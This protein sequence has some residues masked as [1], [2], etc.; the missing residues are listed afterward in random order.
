MGQ[1]RYH[2]YLSEIRSKKASEAV[3]IPIG[4]GPLFGYNVIFYDGTTLLISADDTKNFRHNLTNERNVLVNPKSACITPDGILT[5]ES[6][7]LEVPLSLGKFTGVKEVALIATHL[8]S[9]Q[10]GGTITSYRVY[11]NPDQQ[12]AWGMAFL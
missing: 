12:D 7:E 8:F 11:V 1:I 3:A 4:I 10:E 2:D 9:K 6:S 5:L